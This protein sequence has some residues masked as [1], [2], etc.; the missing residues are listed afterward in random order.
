ML[1]GEGGVWLTKCNLVCAMLRSEAQERH[2][3]CFV[4]AMGGIT[5]VL[6]LVAHDWVF[7]LYRSPALHSSGISGLTVVV[8]E[9]HSDTQSEKSD[10]V[11]STRRVYLVRSSELKAILTFIV[12]K[13]MKYSSGLFP[14]T[15]S[16]Q[17]VACVCVMAPTV[18]FSSIHATCSIKS[19][20]YR[21]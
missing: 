15:P 10:H 6:W 9:Q 19:I 20:I 4:P 7:G 18:K 1:C 5:P 21:A 17:Q 11:M 13:L 8:W 2:Q 16:N 14:G 12:D 3:P